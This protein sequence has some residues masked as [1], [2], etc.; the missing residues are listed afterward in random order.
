LL[1]VELPGDFLRARWQIDFGVE[2]EL[3][4]LPIS[5]TVS[6]IMV[7]L[8]KDDPKV[9]SGKVTFDDLFCYFYIRCF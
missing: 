5:L 9:V 8:K 1:A 3:T 2:S 7:S 4:V 6:K